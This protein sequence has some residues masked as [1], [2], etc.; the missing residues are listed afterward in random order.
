MNVLA[1]PIKRQFIRYSAIVALGILPCACVG[2]FRL[3]T[4]AS[5]D[6]HVAPPA[7]GNKDYPQ[8]LSAILSVMSQDLELPPVAL[9]V[10][11]YPSQQSFEQGV[12]GDAEKDFEELRKRL[13]PFAGQ[14]NR[15]QYI[16]G[17]RAIAV[18]SDALGKHNRILINEWRLEKYRWPEWIRVLA[19]ELTHTV[20]FA[21]ADGRPA[22]WE[23]WL[24]EGFADWVGYKV[25]DRFGAESFAKSIEQRQ[26]EI[27][28]ARVRQTFPALTQLATGADW[29][30]WS[31][32]LGREATYGQALLA[33]DFLIEQKGLPAVLEHV[34]LFRRSFDRKQNFLTAF[35]ESESAF[36]EKFSKHLTLLLGR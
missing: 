12:L 4:V 3:I 7:Y 11:L 2:D 21:V 26:A 9:S 10:A 22:I 6:R 8:A 32:T 35:G 17:A 29:L 5:S 14:L 23:R 16:A 30:T 19:H 1:F 34:R 33:V 36:D 13:G 28:D 24:T 20:E 27:V 18:S 25:L 31:R 15:D